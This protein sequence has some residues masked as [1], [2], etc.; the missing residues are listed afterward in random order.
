MFT[1][2]LTAASIAY[3]TMEAENRTLRARVAELETHVAR[4]A[5]LVKTHAVG[6]PKKV[7]RPTPPLPEGGEEAPDTADYRLNPFDIKGD[8]C[9]GRILQVGSA[10]KRWSPAVYAES[11]CGGNPLEGD[12]L[13]KTC[14]TRADKYAE[15][16][17]SA[18]HWNGRVTEDPPS[19]T[20]MLGTAWARRGQASGKLKWLGG[21]AVGGAGTDTVS[22]TAV[23][24]EAAKAAA[25]AEKAA[26]KAEKA[27][28]KEA[29]KAAAKEATTTA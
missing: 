29:A 14:R 28:A 8:A 11:Q 17:A 13:C 21:A 25:K 3:Q 22:S 9:V 7:A 20:H 2:Q 1:A 19:R 6:R 4:V 23:A 26:A 27:A 24:K 5:E 18:P 15:S 12:D 10:D 16:P